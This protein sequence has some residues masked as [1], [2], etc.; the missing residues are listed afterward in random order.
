MDR[1]YRRRGEQ[2]I[3]LTELMVALAIFA[4]VMTGV[5][6]TWTKAQEAYFVGSD[7][8]ELQQNVRTALDFMV[9]EIQAA[10]RDMTACAFD[11]A[12]GG[13]TDCTASGGGNKVAA[14]AAQIGGAQGTFYSTYTVP[15][16]DGGGGP[17]CSNTYAIPVANAT[18][19]TLRVR[20]DR[21]DNGTIGAALATPADGNDENVLYQ[22]QTTAPPCPEG[23]PACI[24]RD[25]GAGPVAMIAVD[26]SSLIFTYFPK[27]GYAGCSTAPCSAFVPA[28]QA[29]ADNIQRVQITVQALS[30]V[31]GNTVTRT[32]VSDVFLRN[33]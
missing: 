20:A 3:T 26:V 30:V 8:A 13:S 14:C 27:V 12:F 6:A 23:V 7:L 31:A 16:G 15:A 2:G 5:I 21:N 17:G 24:T 19:T 33:R 32:L 25:E 10:G 1:G 29:D 22:L 11:F 18:G 9:R 28:N 4:L